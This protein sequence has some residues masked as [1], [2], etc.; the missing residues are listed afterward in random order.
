VTPYVQGESLPDRP[1]REHQLPLAAAVQTAKDVAAALAYAHSHGVIH[2]DIKPANILI[3]AGRPVIADFG[4]ALA[5]GVAG[6]WRT[7]RTRRVGT[8]FSC[9]RSRT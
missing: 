6:G 2:R 3:Q 1:A 9:A 8:R 4:I 5:V 7:L